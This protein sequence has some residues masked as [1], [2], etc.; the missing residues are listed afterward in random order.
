[1]QVWENEIASNDSRTDTVIERI[2]AVY[3]AEADKKTV[4]ELKK[5][6]KYTEIDIFLSTTKKQFH[7]LK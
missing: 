6:D 5:D 4:E 3:G 7:T 2:T 1:M